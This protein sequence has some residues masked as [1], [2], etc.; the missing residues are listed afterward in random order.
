MVGPPSSRTAQDFGCV[1]VL[2]EAGTVVAVGR[3]VLTS[4]E[5]G[6]IDFAACA[7]AAPSGGWYMLRI[8]GELVGAT[9]RPAGLQAPARMLVSLDEPFEE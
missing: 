7:T 9:L 3:L 6:A 5:D 2:N 4:P 1:E 8:E